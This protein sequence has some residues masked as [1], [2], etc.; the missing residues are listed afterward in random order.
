MIDQTHGNVRPV[1][2]GPQALI[3][4]TLVLAVVAAT[5]SASAASIVV[6]SDADNTNIDDSCTLREAIWNA[7]DDAQINVDCASGSGADTIVFS[8]TGPS[9]RTITLT[10]ALPN[11]T[12]DSVLTIDG[13][14]LGI[15]VS[16]DNQYR[17][18]YLVNGSTLELQH[19]RI[20]K[21]YG[22]GGGGAIMGLGT[23]SLADSVLV[24]NASSNGG[25][26]YVG[27]YGSATILRS[28][29]SDNSADTYGGG[30]FN[31]GSLSVLESTLVDNN[32]VESGGGIHSQGELL[33]ENTTLSGNGAARQSAAPYYDGGNLYLLGNTKIANSTLVHGYARHGGGIYITGYGTLELA[34]SIVGNSASGEDCYGATGAITAKGHSLDTDGSCSGSPWVSTV[35]SAQLDLGPLFW[36]GGPTQTHALN[37]ASVAINAGDA[38]QCVADSITTDQRGETRDSLCDIGAYEVVA[39]P[40]PPPPPQ[41]DL[42]ISN[43]AAKSAKSGKNV[44]YTI[45]ATNGGP[46]AASGVVINDLLATGTGFVSVNAPGATCSTPAVLATGTISCSYGSLASG[47]SIAPMTVVVKVSAK[48]NAQ[49]NNTAS[50]SS[51][52]LD[53]NA[54]NNSATATTKLGK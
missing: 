7:N 2:R 26:I 23:L 40:P 14:S 42:S 10:A 11:V 28:T 15:T 33:L 19:I 51:S 48:G 54:A 46:D 34:N 50:V 20:E 25:A 13:G 9:D 1:S 6:S 30:I 49:L 12:N 47:S 22:T 45:N 39:P 37:A 18:F 41:A 5:G 52:T 43:L 38:T 31:T 35:S 27:P 24:R 17:V 32:A 3:C 53:P 4:R 44:T 36:N 16:G 29:L 21:G 8:F